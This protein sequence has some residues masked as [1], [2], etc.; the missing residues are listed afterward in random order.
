MLE[1]KDVSVHAK[2]T[3]TTFVLVFFLAWHKPVWNALA[4]FTCF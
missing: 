3:N 4:S 1:E 2:E